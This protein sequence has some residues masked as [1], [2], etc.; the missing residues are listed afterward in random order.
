MKI[1]INNAELLISAGLPRQFPSLPIPQIAFSGRSNVGKSSLINTL[2]RRKS[3]ARVSGTPGKTVTVNFYN[4]DSKIMFVD[5][6]GYGFAKRSFEDKKRWSK[7]TDAYFTGNSGIDLLRGVIQLIDSKVGATEDDVQMLN[8]LRESGI[9]FITVYTKCDKLNATQTAELKASMGDNTGA[10][11]E[12]L[13]S[14]K[15]GMGRDELWESAVKLCIASE[16]L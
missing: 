5:L 6:P 3:L 8:F 11:R 14:S 4:I 12:I 2:L 13:F 1:N 16:A 7:L 9:P 10:V 15:T